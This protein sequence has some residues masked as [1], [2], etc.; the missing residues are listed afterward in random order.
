MTNLRGIESKLNSL[1]SYLKANDIHIAGECAEC[2][3]KRLKKKGP[4]KKGHRKKG[5]G[6]MGMEKRAQ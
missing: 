4:K 2:R 1:E 5:T 3:K 6:K